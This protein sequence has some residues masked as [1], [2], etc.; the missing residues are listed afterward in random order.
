M[1]RSL[2]QTTQAEIL[3]DDNI[4]DDVRSEYL[5][6]KGSK[7]TIDGCH[8]ETD[9]VGIRS[10][11]EMCVDLLLLSLVERNEA[12]KD[13]IASSGVVGTTLVVGEVV[14]HGADGKLLLEAVDLVQEENDGCLDEP[15][16]VA[17]RVE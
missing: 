14:L 9:L 7:R 2:Y 15:T 11:C 12:V 8:D 16:R 1:A 5:E 6:K 17:N 10:A 3:L 13:V 4:C